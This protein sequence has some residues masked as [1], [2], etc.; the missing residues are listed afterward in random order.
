[1]SA[2]VEG[3]GEQRKDRERKERKAARKAA[4]LVAQEEGG[5]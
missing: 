5:A 4:K 2:S 1:L 3:E